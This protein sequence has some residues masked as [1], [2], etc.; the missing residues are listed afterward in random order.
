MTSSS[1]GSVPCAPTLLG[2]STIAE[3]RFSVWAEVARSRPFAE[4]VWLA[5]VDISVGARAV[6]LE[7]R[8]LPRW[9]I[10]FCL[11]AARLEGLHFS[12][13]GQSPY[14][15][16][17]AGKD[18]PVLR[19]IASNELLAAA[20]PLTATALRDVPIQRL[21]RHAR[22]ALARVL[23]EQPAESL[24]PGSLDRLE[25]AGALAARAVDP[26]RPG[27]RGRP[28]IEYAQIAARY[29]AYVELGERAAERLAADLHLSKS[30]IQSLLWESR[31]HGLLTKG[32]SGRQGGEL[33]DLAVSLLREE[34]HNA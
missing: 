33:T 2:P 15:P 18:W 21:E 4:G 32:R 10:T 7:W 6:A 3:L 13:F 9:E 20:Q 25:F 26:R 1:E 8:E 22:V 14:R 16:W 12:L 34:G 19:E 5:G 28:L 30:Q 11:G 24:P 23:A 27:Q 17:P 29:V 31:S